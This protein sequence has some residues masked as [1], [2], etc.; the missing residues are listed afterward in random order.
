[1]TWFWMGVEPAAALMSRRRVALADG[2]VA[3]PSGK[4]KRARVRRGRGLGICTVLSTVN[5]W[6][7]S[8]AGIE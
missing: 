8:F 7:C 3:G 5:T 1:M 6:P 2:A 4:S